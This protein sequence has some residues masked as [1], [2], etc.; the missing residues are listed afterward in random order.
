M[1]ISD[2]RKE[3]SLKMNVLDYYPDTK[4]F[5]AYTYVQGI[6][7]VGMPET[8]LFIIELKGH[9]IKPT[10][11]RHGDETPDYAHI[12]H[13][14]KTLSLLDPQLQKEIRGDGILRR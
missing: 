5:E 6:E 4:P 1:H 2:E 13:N 11:T 14:T 8:N 9:H 7:K 3:H 12:I 10:T